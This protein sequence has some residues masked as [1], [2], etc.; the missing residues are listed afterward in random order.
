LQEDLPRLGKAEAFLSEISKVKDVREKLETWIFI[1]EF[2][3]K[4]ACYEPLLMS[5]QTASNQMLQSK[6]FEMIL[7]SVLALGNLLNYGTALGD[8]KGFRL[9][10]LLKLRETKSVN[11]PQITLMNVLVDILESNEEE[12]EDVLGFYEDMPAIEEARKGNLQYVI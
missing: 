2:G 6:R 1:R 7:Q 5:V 4:I 9:E 11:D 10:S 12:G 8:A 3:Y